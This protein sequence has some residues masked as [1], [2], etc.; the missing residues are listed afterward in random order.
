[1]ARKKGDGPVLFNAEHAKTVRALSQYGVPQEDIAATIGCCVETMLKLYG[2]EHKEGR[3][4]ANAKIGKRLFEKA[5]ELYTRENYLMF[6]CCIDGF[7][8]D[9]DVTA[10]TES[11]RIYFDKIYQ[12]GWFNNWK[13]YSLQWGENIRIEGDR[14]YAPVTLDPRILLRFIHERI[15]KHIGADEYELELRISTMDN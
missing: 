11:A 9:V 3:A 14:I 10:H 1:M 5:M 6:I 12:S 4:V 8:V 7:E 15:Q 13:R 2:Q